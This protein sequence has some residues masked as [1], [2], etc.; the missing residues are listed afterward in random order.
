VLEGEGTS[1]IERTL[2]QI[3]ERSA[4]D[5]LDLALVVVRR[6]PGT[7][8]LAALV[9]IAPFAAL[10]VW[11]F[12]A[13]GEDG[14]FFAQVAWMLEAPFA[15][16]PLTVVL[17]GL[18][19]G[20]RPTPGK[21]LG[22]L[23]RGLFPLILVQVLIR[24]VFFMWLSPRL[25][26]ANEVILLERGRWWKVFG[27]GGDLASGR[28]GELFILGFFQLILTYLFAMLF[29]VGMSNL[30][31]A[32]IAEELTWDVPEGS[33]FAGWLFQ[34]PIWLAT[35]FFAVARFLTYIDQRIRLEGWEVELRLRAIGEAMQEARRW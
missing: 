29:Y 8:G 34:L 20:Q 26:F 30:G 13:L 31:A 21:V 17:G 5:L 16:A 1:V 25:A 18:M 27:R 19:F 6:K 32:V 14:R 22:S 3:R 33:L 2:V 15:T 4:V 28:A 24:D 9:G 35:A 12:D 23:L 11:L 10:N 7:L